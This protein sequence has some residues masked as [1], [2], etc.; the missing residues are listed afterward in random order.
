MFSAGGA[1]GVVV[2]F[3]ANSSGFVE[4]SCLN[5]GINLVPGV[6]LYVISVAEPFLAWY[7]TGGML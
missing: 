7:S 6:I 5:I 2:I 3:G 4:M 1:T